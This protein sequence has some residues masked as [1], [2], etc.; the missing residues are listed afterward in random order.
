MNICPALFSEGPT[1]FGWGVEKVSPRK[2]SFRLE[3]HRGKDVFGPSCS[4]GLFLSGAGEDCPQLVRVGVK[5]C[6][7]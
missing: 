4:S 5:L 1:F 7:G 2:L 3:K 6:P